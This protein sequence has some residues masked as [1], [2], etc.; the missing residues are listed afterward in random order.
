VTIHPSAIVAPG[1]QLG[2]DVRVGPFAVIEADVVVGDGCEV[3]AHAVLHD[4]CRLGRRV[5]V[6]PHAVLAGA[7]QILGHAPVPSFV[8]IG[9]DSVIREYV[10]VHRAARE[11]GETRV[12]RRCML[13]ALCH[14]AHD[15][16]IADGAIITSYAALAGHVEIG[17][18]AVL[19]GLAAFHQHVRVGRLAMVG[20]MSRVIQD[21]PPFVIVEGNPC[22]VRGLNSVGLRRAGFAPEARRALKRAFRLL[23]RSG[24]NTSQALRAIQGEPGGDAVDQLVAFVASSKRGTTPAGRADGESGDEPEKEDA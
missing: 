23:Y 24:L 18:S 3:G 22:R 14:L 20:G 6:A 1:A 10:T 19:G 12:G 16:Q 21:V 17:E 7:P 8:T 5:R 2:S 9:D 15:C 4:G 13:M 11:G